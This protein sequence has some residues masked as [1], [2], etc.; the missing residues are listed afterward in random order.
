MYVQKIGIPAQCRCLYIS[1]VA[2]KS[3]IISALAQLTGA[4]FI[5]VSCAN[6]LIINYLG[7]TNFSRIEPVFKLMYRK[8]QTPP[9]RL[10]GL[11]TGKRA[12]G[13]SSRRFAE[14]NRG[15][16]LA[17]NAASA[18]KSSVLAI[19]F[20]LFGLKKKSLVVGNK[21]FARIR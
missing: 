3:H 15:T 20:R 19:F 21:A 5:P 10:V 16:P 8:R 13:A 4:F 12:G 11:R 7:A 9:F 2:L 1:V 18:C 17:R 6:Q 14:G